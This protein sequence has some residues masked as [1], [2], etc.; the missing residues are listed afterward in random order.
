MRQDPTM[1]SPSKFV[2]EIEEGANIL[3]KVERSQIFWWCYESKEKNLSNGISL[4]PYVES[5][6]LMFDRS[7]NEKLREQFANKLGDWLV[8]FVM[9]K[10][11]DADMGFMYCVGARSAKFVTTDKDGNPLNFSGEANIELNK[12][13]D[14]FTTEFIHPLPQKDDD[15]DQK[16]ASRKRKSSKK[17]EGRKNK[18]PRR[19]TRNRKSPDR[20]TCKELG[21]IQSKSEAFV[22]KV[23]FTFFFVFTMSFFSHASHYRHCWVCLLKNTTASLMTSWKA[24]LKRSKPRR[25]VEKMVKSF[26]ITVLE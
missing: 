19:S 21:N 10:S 4:N 12:L 11:I 1:S 16:V 22:E 6:I 20:L 3:S 14:W 7:R 2:K 24:I 25:S 8:Q 13:K 23:M 15:D 17:K 5:A 18:K 9:D 26:L